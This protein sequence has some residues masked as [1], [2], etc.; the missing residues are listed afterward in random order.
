MDVL[1]Q[2]TPGDFEFCLLLKLKLVHKSCSR[3]HGNQ[4]NGMCCPHC[5]CSNYV[6]GG[7]DESACVVHVQ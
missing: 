2:L 6:L 5:A 7:N 1:L 3:S 4:F